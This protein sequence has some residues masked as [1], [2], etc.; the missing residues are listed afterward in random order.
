MSNCQHNWLQV[1]KKIMAL[2]QKLSKEGKMGS[3]WR[4]MLAQ[5][6]WKVQWSICSVK[7]TGAK[8]I[9]VVALLTLKGH[10]TR[11]EFDPLIRIIQYLFCCKIGRKIV[12]G[13]HLTF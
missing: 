11:D 6:V 7:D 8:F 4:W 12:A 2:L 10:D 13:V 1:D 3:K 5:G 9:P